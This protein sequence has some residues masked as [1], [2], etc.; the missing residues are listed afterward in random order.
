[1]GFMGLS[2][3]VESDNAA[4]FRYTL[5]KQF[6]K[7]AKDP[8][9]LKRAVRAVVDNELKDMANDYNTPGMV[10]LALVLEAEGDPG[11]PKYD[12]PGL[13]VFSN[14]LTVVQLQKAS[15]LFVQEMPQW[16][17]EHKSRLKQ[18]HEV[19]TSALRRARRKTKR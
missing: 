13:P 15:K 18:L 2:S 17:P 16:N 5:Q 11:N 3:W 19:I 9:A 4:D 12:D 8:A 6:E 7:F 14:L 10:N 1:M